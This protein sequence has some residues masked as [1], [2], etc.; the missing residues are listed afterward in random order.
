MLRDIVITLCV[1]SEIQYKSVEIY[2]NASCK[3][4]HG[5]VLAIAAALR[6]PDTRPGCSRI[7]AGTVIDLS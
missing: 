7:K 5:Y 4:K 1:Q 6:L 2:D 3:F